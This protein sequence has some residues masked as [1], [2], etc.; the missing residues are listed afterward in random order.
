MR[1]A[2]QSMPHPL[3]CVGPQTTSALLGVATLSLSGSH[4]RLFAF[5][6]KSDIAW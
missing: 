2:V 6:A 5:G 4:V 3:T 1:D